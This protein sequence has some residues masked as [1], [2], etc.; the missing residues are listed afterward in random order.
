MSDHEHHHQTD[1]RAELEA[2]RHQAAHYYEHQ[3]DWRGHPPP[4][5][6]T[7]PRF[8]PISDEWQREAWL[9]TAAPG[10]GDHV[11]LPTSTGKLRDMTVAGQLVFEVGGAEQR[12]TLYIGHGR[13]GSEYGFLPFRDA[14]SG[15]ETYGSGR[16]LDVPYDPAATDYLLD[17]NWAYNPSCAFSPAYDC[18]YPPPGNRLDVRVEAGEMVPFEH[19][20]LDASE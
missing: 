4:A 2:A 12:L 19:P 17:F 3:F 5:D 13:D 6:F 9:D 14:T 1:W 11:T 8:F 10:S 18:P 15:H 16:Y 7:G 20:L